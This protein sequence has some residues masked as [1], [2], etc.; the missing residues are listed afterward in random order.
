MS[1]YDIDI[2]RLGLLLLPTFLRRP[3]MAAL[4]Y[5]VL[6]PL[7]SLHMRLMLFR[8]EAAYR[9]DH[10]GQ[11]CHLRAVLNDLFD[12]DLRRIVIEEIALRPGLQFVHC[13][14]TEQSVLVPLRQAGTRLPVVRRG[15]GDENGYDF[16]VN[17]P[18]ALGGIDEARL[19]A[20]VRNYKLASKRF[21]IS[22]IP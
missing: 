1:R 22:Y 13:R 15:F 19:K 11:V 2:K 5:A 18:L 6:T 21:A 4:L 7:A 16:A 20:V 10:N 12:P 8:R 17:V 9:L 3:V 14:E